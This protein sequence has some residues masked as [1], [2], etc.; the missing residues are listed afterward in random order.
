GV[1]S[2]R[3]WQPRRAVS[4]PGEASTQEEISLEN[5]SGS[6]VDVA[7]QT[8][9]RGTLEWIQ[10]LPNT[11]SHARLM[12][13]ALAI[14]IDRS[15]DEAT[16]LD[17]ELIARSLTLLPEDARDRIGN[18]IGQK[19]EDISEL[20]TWIGRLPDETSRAAAIEQMV[21]QS[22]EGFDEIDRLVAEF[23]A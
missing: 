12:E 6:V 1:D 9:P 8:N 22:P 4:I 18:K 10:A 21:A 2:L 20:R 19:V 15:D 16:K 17:P 3:S 23:P 14:A 11:E 13:Q 5:V 7:F